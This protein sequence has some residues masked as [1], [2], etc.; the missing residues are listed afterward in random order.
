MA[1]L[2]DEYGG[3]AG[4]VTAEDILEEIVGEIRDEFDADELP[5][6]QK[7]GENHYILDAKLLISEAN[8][9]L[10][11]TLSDDD[12]DTIGG[13]FMTQKYDAVQGDFIEEE[14]YRFIIKEMDGHHISYIEVVKI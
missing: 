13:W 8:D 9:L 7:S 2:L 3:T 11:T 6:I 10:G 1:I 12:V 4:L 5:L 14:G